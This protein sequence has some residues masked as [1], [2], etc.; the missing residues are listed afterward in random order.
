VPELREDFRNYN[1]DG[2]GRI[3]LL[4]FREF[5]TSLDESI[6]DTVMMTGYRD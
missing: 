1:R 3:N 5:V 2:D 6:S 4:E